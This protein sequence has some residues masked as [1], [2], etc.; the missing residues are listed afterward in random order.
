MRSKRVLAAVMGLACLA[1]L[2]L[3]AQGRSDSAAAMEIARPY[4]PVSNN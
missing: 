4:M 2:P 1:A 3:A